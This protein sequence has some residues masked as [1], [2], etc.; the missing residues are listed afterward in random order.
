MAG[1]RR[2]FYEVLGVARDADTTAVKDALRELAKKHH[3]DR[4]KE[5]RSA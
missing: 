5:Q 1:A 4:N 3:P 2:D